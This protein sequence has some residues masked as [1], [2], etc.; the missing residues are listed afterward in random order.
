[1]PVHSGFHHDFHY[2]FFGGFYPYPNYV[3]VYYGGPSYYTTYNVGPDYGTPMPAAGEQR[4]NIENI[5][6]PKPDIPKIEDIPAPK[7]AEPKIEDIPAPKPGAQNGGVAEIDLT[8]PADANV[9]FQGIK[10]KQTGLVRLLVTPPL[11][12][13][14]SY[15]YEIRATYMENGREV[16]TVRNL[17]VRAGDRLEALLIALPVASSSSTTVTSGQ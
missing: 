14:R 17:S 15:S 9:W 12:S 4:P 7:P 8:V 2:P 1:V 11:K 10:I 13:G 5:P 3:S 6:A 16:T